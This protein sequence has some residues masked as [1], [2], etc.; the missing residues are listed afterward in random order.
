[1]LLLS[2]KINGCDHSL[3][4]IQYYKVNCKKITTNI[5]KIIVKS[6]NIGDE[7]TIR[8]AWYMLLFFGKYLVANTKMLDIIL[9]I[10]KKIM[11]T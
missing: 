11:C 9:I 10:N 7:N 3:V 5:V 8:N 1:M 6:A 2:H 4:N